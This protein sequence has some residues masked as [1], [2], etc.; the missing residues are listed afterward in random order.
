[1]TSSWKAPDD[2]KLEDRI[3][4]AAFQSGLELSEAT[5]HFFQRRINRLGGHDSGNTDLDGRLVCGKQRLVQLLPRPYSSERDIYVD[6]RLE[7]GKPDHP[8]GKLRDLHRLP[9]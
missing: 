4:I 6:S 3:P 9:H 8:F 7:T 1:M 2:L 5:A